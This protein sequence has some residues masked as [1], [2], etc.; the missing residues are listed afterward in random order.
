MTG[1]PTPPLTTEAEI[2]DAARSSNPPQPTPMA[3]DTDP[4]TPP[5]E[6]PPQS[7]QTEPASV[8]DAEPQGT[9]YERL[10]LTLADLAA[11]GR[12][13]ELALEAERGDAAEG[14][15]HDV[16]RLFVLAPLVLA[17]LVLDDV[18]AARHALTRLPESHL[19]LPVSMSLFGI[20]TAVHNRQHEAVYARAEDLFNLCHQPALSGGKLG[21]VL[22][23]MTT[24]FI[25]A[26]RTKTFTLLGKAY[27][28]ISVP[29]AQSYLGLP[30]DQIL[31]AAANNGWAYDAAAQVL[32]PPRSA[33]RTRVVITDPS[34]LSTLGA[35]VDGIARV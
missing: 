19:R 25:D 9:A 6:Q 5:P 26:F 23:G 14:N 32:T 17:Y 16:T 22:A 30:I 31:A 34:T 2:Q 20:L 1:P 18:A 21:T 35:V 28:T 11:Q 15:V 29:L 4:T 27:T 12:Y 3:T 10:F 33:T 13:R 7:Q 24:A 8:T